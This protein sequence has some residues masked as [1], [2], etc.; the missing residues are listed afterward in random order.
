M[1]KYVIIADG[2]V[3]KTYPTFKAA[4]WDVEFFQLMYKEVAV[5]QMILKNGE[6]A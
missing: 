2:E 3:V 4:M 6:P 5:Y 1:E